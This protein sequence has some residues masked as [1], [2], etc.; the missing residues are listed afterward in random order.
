MD[1]WPSTRQDKTRYAAFNQARA[2]LIPRFSI[3]HMSKRKAAEAAIITNNS[4]AELFER[5]DAKEAIETFFIQATKT[6]SCLSGICNPNEFAEEIL[7]A[8][9]PYKSH[10]KLPQ[11]YLTRGAL[12]IFQSK[13]PPPT[14]EGLPP[15]T[16]AILLVQKKELYEGLVELSVASRKVEACLKSMLDTLQDLHDKGHVFP[17]Y[18]FFT[19]VHAPGVAMQSA[20]SAAAAASQCARA[21]CSWPPYTC[22]RFAW[23]RP[24]WASGP[25]PT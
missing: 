9:K 14:P 6:A 16:A 13:A 25:R 2:E 12:R 18:T 7:C 10:K 20:C 22:P 15:A 8:Y 4:D 5:Q 21:P 11:R 23:C 17:T 24:A 3:V 19:M 1:H